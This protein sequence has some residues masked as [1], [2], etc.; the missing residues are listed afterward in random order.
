MSVKLFSRVFCFFLTKTN[1][2][3]KVKKIDVIVMT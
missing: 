1:L 2:K 3:K